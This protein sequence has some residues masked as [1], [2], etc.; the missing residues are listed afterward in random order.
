[1]RPDDVAQVRQN[2]EPGKTGDGD[3]EPIVGRTE[4]EVQT[5]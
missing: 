2:R 3:S 1:M 5:D 4:G